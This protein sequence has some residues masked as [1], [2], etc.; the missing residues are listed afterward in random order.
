MDYSIL[1]GSM[2]YLIYDHGTY[3]GRGI[4]FYCQRRPEAD[5]TP[6]HT[7][8]PLLVVGGL[9]HHVSE[10]KNRAGGV[11]GLRPARSSGVHRAGDE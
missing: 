7:K 2:S 9:F 6:D 1:M 5:D 3:M 4:T 11:L 10:V 8:P